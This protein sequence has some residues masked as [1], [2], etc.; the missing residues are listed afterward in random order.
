MTKENAVS[1][2]VSE[3]DYSSDSESSSGCMGGSSDSETEEKPET[4]KT[5]EEPAVDLSAEVWELEY[6]EQ[7][8]LFREHEMNMRG[9]FVKRQIG[10][11]FSLTQ[12]I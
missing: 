10:E 1:E 8:K 5:K 9:F 3:A 7:Q 4:V 6:R 2:A 11:H 12:R